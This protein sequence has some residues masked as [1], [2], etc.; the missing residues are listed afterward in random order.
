MIAGLIFGDVCH[1]TMSLDM[2]QLGVGGQQ[3]FAEEKRT[4]A[5]EDRTLSEC[6]V[7]KSTAWQPM[8]STGKRMGYHKLLQ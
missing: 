7:N 5:S 2:R 6:H 1:W 4:W 3:I 8:K